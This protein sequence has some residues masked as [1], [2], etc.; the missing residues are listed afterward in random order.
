VGG[1]IGRKFQLITVLIHDSLLMSQTKSVVVVGQGNVALDCARLLAKPIS[2][3]QT[4]DLTDAAL[5]KL[6]SSTVK[7]IHV[8]GRRGHIQAAFTIKE[9]R[10]LTKIPG[11][12]LKIFDSELQAG[13]TPSS[14]EEL[15]T[16]RPLKR[17]TDLIT[18]TA[19]ASPPAT[20][21]VDKTINIRFFLSPVECIE[22]VVDGQ[23]TGA[24]SS[25]VFEKCRLE[26]PPHAQRA[27]STG[28]SL[29]FSLRHL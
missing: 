20:N 14:E 23:R 8:A 22:G 9:L 29:I 10:E 4:S 2:D 16:K 11:V 21:E 17:I 26:G 7:D 6:A 5:Q 25:V 1:V 18:T 19:A 13:M 28:T 27:I 24:V 3:L 15:R 12:H